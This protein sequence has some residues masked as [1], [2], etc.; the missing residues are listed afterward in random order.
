[1]RRNSTKTAHEHE[2]ILPVCTNTTHTFINKFVHCPR[3]PC[4]KRRKMPQTSKPIMHLR[5][6]WHQYESE[7]LDTSSPPSKRCRTQSKPCRTQRELSRT[8]EALI[9]VLRTHVY[10]HTQCKYS[11]QTPVLACLYDCLKGRPCACDRF[12]SQP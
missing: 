11:T 1:M 7:A 2:M 3:R 4:A 9:Q 8:R 10:A 12:A 6:N 5:A